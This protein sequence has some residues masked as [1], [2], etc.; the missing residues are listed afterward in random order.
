MKMVQMDAAVNVGV[1]FRVS[2]RVPPA[3][4]QLNE[5]SVD[6]VVSRGVLESW[7]PRAMI[8]TFLRCRHG[9]TMYVNGRLRYKL[10]SVTVELW[11]SA[12]TR[13]LVRFQVISGYMD[14]PFLGINFMQNHYLSIQHAPG[15]R[16]QALFVVKHEPGV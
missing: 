5:H 11:I 2:G 8:G 4:I 14:T 16:R 9:E 3:Y 6:N 12:D 10:G 13:V 1:G 7:G 15:H